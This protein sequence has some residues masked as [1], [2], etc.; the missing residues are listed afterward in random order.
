MQD[1][2]DLI[3]FNDFKVEDLQDISREHNFEITERIKPTCQFSV[4]DCTQLTPYSIK[5]ELILHTS[6]RSI[7]LR[8]E[9]P[10]YQTWDYELII[11]HTDIPEWKKHELMNQKRWE[12]YEWILVLPKFYEEF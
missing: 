7:V 5:Y 4:E 1:R 9:L 8:W 3:S 11:T 10:E 2:P 6:S 12:I